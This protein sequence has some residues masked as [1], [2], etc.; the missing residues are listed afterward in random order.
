MASKIIYQT[1]DI[2]IEHFFSEAKS[3]PN[4]AFVFTPSMNRNL[5]GNAYGGDLLLRNAYDVIA[6][7]ISNDDWF[8]GIPF[9][10][11]DAI[12]KICCER[13]YLKR[14][15]YGSSMGGYAVIAFSKLLFIDIGLVFSPQYSIDE[16]FDTRWLAFAKKIS[17]KYRI[18]KTTIHNNCSFVCV[19]DDKNLD[20]I[21]AE[22]IKSIVSS[23]KIKEIILPYSG[24]PVTHFL[25]ESGVLKDIV[26]DCINSKSL[27][28]RLLR[29]NRRISKSYLKSISEY[30]VARGRNMIALKLID[31]A[32]VIQANDSSLYKIK[33][34]IHEKIGCIEDAIKSARLAVGLDP[35]D[36]HFFASLSALEFKLG[37]YDA[38]LISIENAIL[39]DGG[40]S[41][42]RK[43]KSVILNKQGL[44]NDALVEAKLA[45]KLNDKDPH[46][47]IHLSILLLKS[48]D[49]VNALLEV[50]KAISVDASI[51]SFHN[52]KRT[53][54][55]QL[56]NGLS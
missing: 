45:T 43:H 9:E 40:V 24:H 10:L 1:Q 56:Y 22:K 12:N 15:G 26:L 48:G 13:G 49:L 30:L 33:S 2:C 36:A 52:H 50:E 29:K 23:D 55:R 41:G 47:L 4:V 5:L 14:I 35:K 19:F 39:I 38:A 25:S 34:K 3:H 32:I 46:S 27:D 54:I 16:S 21:H 7:K 18:D 37:D 11:F 51:E 6:F 31:M 53:I 28:I 20:R 8:Q 42:F 17:W 44:L